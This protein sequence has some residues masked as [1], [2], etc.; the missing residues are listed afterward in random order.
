[1]PVSARP[2]Y[3]PEDIVLEYGVLR[4]YP[5][6][7]TASEHVC[8]FSSNLLANDG[9]FRASMRLTEFA[10]SGVIYHAI[11]SQTVSSNAS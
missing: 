2:I 5:R 6:N 7:G 10:A 4:D 8:L 11:R 1:M 3:A 9:F